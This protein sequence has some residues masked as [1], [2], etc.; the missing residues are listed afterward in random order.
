MEQVRQKIDDDQCGGIEVR[1]PD[2]VSVMN[3]EPS[4]GADARAEPDPGQQGAKYERGIGLDVQRNNL[5]EEKDQDK[6]L[7]Q[8]CQK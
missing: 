1:S 4:G 2:Q 3:E 8:R 7:S 5:P 6:Q